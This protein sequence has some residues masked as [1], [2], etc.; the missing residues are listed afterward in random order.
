MPSSSIRH[1]DAM[2]VPDRVAAFLDRNFKVCAALL[3]V[4]LLACAV[5]RDLRKKLWI[6]ELYTLYM[7]EQPSVGEIVRATLEGCDGAPPLYAILV[8]A[9][10]P[11]VGSDALA[12]R[13]P[14]SLGYGGAVI[15]LLAFCRR[16]MPACYAFVAA[17]LFASAALSYA[18]EGRCYGLVLGSGAGALFC[19]QGACD[20]RRRAIAIPLLA[21]SAAL[22]TTLHYY[23]VFFLFALFCAEIARAKR[24]GR[25]DLGVL[26]ALASP[27]LILA[28]HYP[29]IEEGRRF[30][31]H[32]WA[33]ASWRNLRDLTGFVVM[34]TPLVLLAAFPAR[35]RIERPPSLTMAEW[36]ATAGI[37]VMPFCVLVLSIYVTHVWVQRYVMWADVGIAV[38][39]A[40]MLYA[41]SAGQ[42]AP[43]VSAL[44]LLSI[45]LIISDI[46]G[47]LKRP[48]LFEGQAV[49]QSLQGVGAGS[50]PIVIA[51]HHVFMELFYYAP[52]SLR[53]RFIYPVD[54]ELDLHYSGQDTGALLMSAW[55]RRWP[56]LPIVS[57]DEVL[58]AHSHFLVAAVPTDYLPVQ[59]AGIGYRLTRVASSPPALLYQVT[60]PDR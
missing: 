9:I 59:L 5:G 56:Q 52:P 41:R 57:Y 55:R 14:S 2:R 35:D 23:S 22:M 60:A 43:A 46:G 37:F 20:R 10:H 11:L 15:L 39:V 47:V 38:L 44:A 53:Q 24:A 45:L 6:D 36:F 3:V 1:Q 50:E 48:T 18:T 32:Y 58:A 16:R 12:V 7:S 28:V 17:T 29:L 51:D 40:A 27:L 30:Q 42:N 26:A 54:R 31:Q 33:I 25:L 13:L 34:F 21:C 4:F 8:H 19:W 49:F